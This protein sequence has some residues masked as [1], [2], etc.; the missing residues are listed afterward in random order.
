MK[1]ES[2]GGFQIGAGLVLLLS[3]AALTGCI[4]HEVKLITPPCTEEQDVMMKRIM[5]CKT[6]PDQSCDIG[7]PPNCK[8][9]D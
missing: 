8:C 3:I 2:R 1:R 6:K 7:N 5:W 9:R 4:K